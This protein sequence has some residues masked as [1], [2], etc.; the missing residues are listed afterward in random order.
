MLL[1]TEVSPCFALMGA[2]GATPVTS[3]DGITTVVLSTLDFVYTSAT[4]VAL[5][6]LVLEDPRAALSREPCAADARGST[7]RIRAAVERSRMIEALG[8]SAAAQWLTDVRRGM[9]VAP[10]RHHLAVILAMAFCLTVTI[11][12]A[13]L[14]GSSREWQ[15]ESWNAFVD[16]FNSMD[17]AYNNLAPTYDEMNSFEQQLFRTTGRFLDLVADAVNSWGLPALEAL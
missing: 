10:L 1:A 5:V 16:V 7:S 6:S 9:L 15:V 13:V 11:V 12:A 4:L 8:G 3:A 17:D 2:G 14:S